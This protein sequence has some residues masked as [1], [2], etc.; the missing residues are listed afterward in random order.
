M[1]TATKNRERRLRYRAQHHGL[2]L[3]R[4]RRQLPGTPDHGRYALGT[5]TRITRARSGP[6][7][8]LTLDDVEAAL[9]AMQ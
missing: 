1:D 9:D 5:P 7:Y 2:V 8:T 4:S 3:K 6:E